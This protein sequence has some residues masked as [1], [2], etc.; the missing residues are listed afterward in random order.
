MDG[1]GTRRLLDFTV[2]SL[3]VRG[4]TFRN[5]YHQSWGAA[6]D[7]FNAKP[8]GTH[9][10]AT[11]TSCVFENNQR[12][13]IMVAFWGKALVE[14]CQFIGNIGSG[15]VAVAGNPLD[16]V[17]RNSQFTDNEH[18][19]Y[20]D[21][22]ENVTVQDCSFRGNGRGILA[23][24]DW[25]NGF[26]N[27]VVSG[28]LFRDNDVG[29]RTMGYRC[30]I[31]NNTFDANNGNAGRFYHSPTTLT[32]NIA[33]GTKIGHAFFL[34]QEWPGP[35]PPCKIGMGSSSCN[36]FWNNAGGSICGFPMDTTDVVA[37]PMYCEA[38][39]GDY[40]VSSVGR[41][42]PGKS[43]CGQLVGA[44]PVGCSSS[45]V[46]VAGFEA[47]Y[48]GGVVELSWT[49]HSDEDFAGFRLI[50]EDIERRA[51]DVL[52]S[53]GLLGPS[54]RRYVDERAQPGR[55][56]TYALVVVDAAGGEVRS[57]TLRVIVGQIGFRLDQN[58]PN[59]FN[60]TTLI[61]YAVGSTSRV[62]LDVYDVEGGH[63][64]SLVDAVQVTGARSA[65]WD[66]R[67][68]AGNRVSSG[69]YF[70]RLRAGKFT[71]TRKLMLLK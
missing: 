3:L 11:V 64:R 39:A 5:G 32:R 19:V 17:C 1:A 58:H 24:E 14:D 71:Q 4:F 68:Y 62:T 21:G 40:T 15:A 38:S 67:N 46:T 30:T 7:I 16:F 13:A 28:C 53:E 8:Y 26:N 69:V 42:A 33:T 57:R 29:I 34:W 60:P 25:Y 12:G 36:V 65:V 45:P 63:V 59:P 70:Y 18:G 41:A 20:T 49:I 23:S 37:D 51:V 35:P 50:R 31:T 54:I 22:A 10:H 44:F 61:N 47:L 66:G 48:E 9:S 52:P 2:D 56:Y 27:L 6:I 55:E 43:L